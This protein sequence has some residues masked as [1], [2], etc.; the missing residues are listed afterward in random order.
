MKR[1]HFQITIYKLGIGIS[2]AYFEMAHIAL[3]KRALHVYIVYMYAYT[4]CT[5]IL[6]IHM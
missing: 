2:Y 3:W 1:T 4:L 5:Y 6:I